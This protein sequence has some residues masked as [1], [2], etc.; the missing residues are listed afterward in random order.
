MP[1]DCEKMEDKQVDKKTGTVD[2]VL[3]PVR[4]LILGLQHVLIMYSGAVAVPLMLG[5]AIGLT[6][7]QIA[8]LVSADL[9][10][11]G[12]A[13]IIQTLGISRFIGIR[14]PLMMG[15]TMI[16]IKPMISIGS[17][18]G[19]RHIYGA[20]IVSAL[21]VFF[22]S[23]IFSKLQRFFPN[24]VTGS[25]ITVIGFSLVPLAARW[26]GGDPAGSDWGAPVHLAV[27]VGVLLTVILITRFC[28][29]FIGSCAV[30][31]SMVLGSLTA[32]FLGHMSLTGISQQHWLAIPPPFW[33]GMPQFD[34]VAILSMILISFVSFI[35]S[36]G[37]F[38]ATGRTVN[39][40][41]DC[42]DI[43]RGLRAESLATLLGSFFNSFPYITFSQ[44]LGLVVMSGV[45]SRFVVATGGIIL[46]IL[47]L[48]PK[49]GAIIASIPSEVLGGAS[50]V[51][52]GMVGIT[53]IR[54]LCEANIESN[55]NIFIASLAISAG[56]G[57]SFVPNLFDSMNQSMKMIL[58]NGIIVTSFIAVALNLL[59]RKREQ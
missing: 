17:T 42:T 56:I 19:M 2:E 1:E 25:I 7:H 29:E 9:L 22:C 37:V 35:E 33:F 46:V 53:G 14:L 44:N 57:V 47:G 38:I 23:G 45:R 30:L 10:T 5:N 55:E 8:L 16:A 20:I 52:F 6:K 59:F 31:I 3:H 34:V 58:S 50:I 39:V 40:N 21:V 12:I 32:F 49:L 27:A 11:C 4:N 15:V 48:F 43:A 24:V 28:S 51:M 26:C 36:T 41:V 54:M 13:T 18:L